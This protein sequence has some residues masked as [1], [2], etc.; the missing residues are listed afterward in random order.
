MGLFID[1]RA[2][3]NKKVRLPHGEADFLIVIKRREG[4]LHLSPP[5]L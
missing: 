5:P 3:V 1:Y 2:K 4:A